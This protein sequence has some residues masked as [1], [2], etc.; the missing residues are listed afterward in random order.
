MTGFREKLDAQRKRH[1]REGL[2]WIGDADL[3]KYWRRRHPYVRFT[4]HL[5]AA[6]NEAHA[7]GRAAGRNIVLQRAMHERVSRGRLLPGRQ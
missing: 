6:Q 5:G 3:T 2:V 4:R 1:A 7:H